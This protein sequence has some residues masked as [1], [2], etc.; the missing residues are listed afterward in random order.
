[1]IVL[2]RITTEGTSVK[3]GIPTN[4]ISEVSE[5]KDEENRLWVRYWNGQEIRSMVVEGTVEEI[6]NQFNDVNG[7]LK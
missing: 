7:K 5:H 4:N 6:A 3:I 2:N 1:M